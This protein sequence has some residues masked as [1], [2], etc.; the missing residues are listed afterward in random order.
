M[1]GFRNLDCRDL[2]GFVDGTENPQD[3]HRAEVALLEGGEFPVDPMSMS[4]AG[5]MP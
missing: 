4:S 1:R 2:T 3:E 5:C